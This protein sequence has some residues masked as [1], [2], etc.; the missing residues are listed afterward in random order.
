[1]PLAGLT[2]SLLASDL[3]QT[4]D[5][6][7]ALGFRLSG[8]GVAAGWFEVRRDGV[9]LQFYS[10][11]PV[12]TPTAPTMSGTIYVP[13]DGVERLAA[14]LAGKVAFEW[15]PEVMDYGMR[16]F[17]VRDPNGYLIAFTEPA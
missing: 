15:G 3:K 1:M 17:A 6:Y 5:F 10:D 14:D 11:P 9:C 8:G 4:R 16:E 12:D 7:E 2:L 13:T